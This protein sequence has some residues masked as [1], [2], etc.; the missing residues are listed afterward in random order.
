MK[1][2]GACNAMQSL[3]N[4]QTGSTVNPTPMF[5]WL[6]FLRVLSM[7]HRLNQQNDA[8]EFLVYLIAETNAAASQMRWEARICKVGSCHCHDYGSLYPRTHASTVYKPLAFSG[9]GLCS[10]KTVQTPLPSSQKVRDRTWTNILE[11]TACWGG[12]WRPH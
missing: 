10:S 2:W 1:S 12:G 6:A 9:C 5:A 11:S 8:G 4:L 7:Q 3:Q